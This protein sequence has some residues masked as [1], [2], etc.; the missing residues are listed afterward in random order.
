MPLLNEPGTVIFD[1][2][3]RGSYAKFASGIRAGERPMTEALGRQ[4]TFAGVYKVGASFGA[5]AMMITSDQTYLS[6]NPKVPPGTVSVGLI[7]VKPGYDIEDVARRIAAVVDGDDSKAITMA[8]FIAQTRNLLRKE[9]PIAYIFS[10]GV[11][12]GLIVGV[13]IVVQ[14]LTTDVQDHLPEYATFKAMGFSNGRL[15]SIV[16]EQSVILTGL[17]FIPGLIVSLGAYELVRRA[18]SM[19]IAMPADRIALVFG[20]TC[21]MCVLAG[22]VA[23][24][25]V[26]QADPAEVF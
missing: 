8:A 21:A 24:R 20:L 3:S 25:R 5:E 16:Y 4:I 9:S 19:P 23:I 22:T 7:R 11:I 17:G 2:G 12:M 18:V 13:I 1:E 10:F 14:I 26:A 15:L 6:L